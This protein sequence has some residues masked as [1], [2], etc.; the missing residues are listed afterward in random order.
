MNE[1]LYSDRSSDLNDDEDGQESEQ[2]LSEEQ[3]EV[4]GQ[5]LSTSKRSKKTS[6][7]QS[8]NKL[9]K[10]SSKRVNSQG[11][12]EVPLTSNSFKLSEN[13]RI[14]TLNKKRDESV[15]RS[16]INTRMT[17]NSQQRKGDGVSPRMYTTHGVKDSRS[18]A[19][20]KEQMDYLAKKRKMRNNLSDEE[21]KEAKAQE[22]AEL[23]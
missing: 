17:N 18:P 2:L 11:G 8:S 9:K 21:L 23:M 14:D 16:G 5:G 13:G 10:P 6:K 1:E 3:D 20:V 19:S 15:S 22:E 12:Q 7:S 4:E